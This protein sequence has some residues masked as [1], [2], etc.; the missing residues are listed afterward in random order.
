MKNLHLRK[1]LRNLILAG[2]GACALLLA[3]LAVAYSQRDPLL[4]GLDFGRLVPADQCFQ[5]IE[6]FVEEVLARRESYPTPSDSVLIE[7]KG[8]DPKWSFRNPDPPR[9]KRRKRGR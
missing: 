7:S 5:A 9:R 1:I 6:Q 3:G 2:L 8:F 4:K